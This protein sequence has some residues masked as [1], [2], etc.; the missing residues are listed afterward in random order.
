[1]DMKTITLK[2]D[3]EF[4][5]KVTELAKR[6]HMSKSEL[7]RE[8]IRNYEKELQRKR[9]K[10]LLQKESLASRNMIKDEQRI[11]EESLEDGLTDD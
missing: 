10:K 9:L 5:A 8:A 2:T 11:W 6:L 1:M 7:I 4:F 3:D